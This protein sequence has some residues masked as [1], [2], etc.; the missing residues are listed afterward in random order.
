MPITLFLGKPLV[1]YATWHMASRGLLTTI[2]MAFGDSF[3]ACCVAVFT[4][5]ALVLI[6]SSLLIPGFLGIPA[7][8]IM[9]S[10]FAEASKLFEPE[11]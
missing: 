1:S 3:A 2:R 5:P 7:V 8:I 4:I 11:R 9:I 10:D 6:R